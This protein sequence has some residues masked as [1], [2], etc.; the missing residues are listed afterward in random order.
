MPKI[1]TLENFTKHSVIDTLAND[2]KILTVH[3]LDVRPPAPE[4]QRAAVPFFTTPSEQF[5]A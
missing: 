3:S 1:Q 2:E 4:W 5:S